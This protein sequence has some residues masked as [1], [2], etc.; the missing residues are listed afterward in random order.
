MTL[1]QKLHLAELIVRLACLATI[2]GMLYLI[3]WH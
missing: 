2:V 1:P 3:L